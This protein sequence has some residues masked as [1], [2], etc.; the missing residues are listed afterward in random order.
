MT[1][2]DLERRLDSDAAALFDDAVA[3]V[4]PRKDGA[5][6]NHR[7]V[8]DDGRASFDMACSIE[9][10]PPALRGESLSAFGREARPAASFDGVVTA[11]DDG[12]WPYVPHDGDH[13]EI[14]GVTYKIA[15]IHRDGSRRRV[16]YVNKAR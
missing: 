8:A 15:D 14:G 13:L 2:A 11:T 9:L 12:T 10:N 3:T 6:V 4:L 7:P 1:W 16:F 5:T